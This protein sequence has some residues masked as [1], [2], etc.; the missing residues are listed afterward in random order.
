MSLEEIMEKYAVTTKILRRWMEKEEFVAE[1]RRVSEIL[2]KQTQHT[3]MRHAPA[4]AR[5][6]A[7]LVGNEKSEVARRAAVDLLDR[8]MKTLKGQGDGGAFEDRMAKVSEEEAR[9]MLLTLARGLGKEGEG[10]GE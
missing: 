7:E 2:Q 3:L 8:C 6:L 10:P 4:A 5:R 1:M 9:R